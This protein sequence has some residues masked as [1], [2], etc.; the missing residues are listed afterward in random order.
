MT[1]SSLEC[2]TVSENQSARILRQALRDGDANLWLLYKRQTGGID[3]S[4]TDWHEADLGRYDLSGTD[5]TAAKL[6]GADL[7]DADLTGAI[8]RGAS[9]VG[10]NLSRTCL[11][12][13]DLSGARLRQAH[14]VDTI[15]LRVH[16]RGACFDGAD[17]MRADLRGADLSRADLRRARFKDTDGREALWQGAD[18]AEALLSGLR[19]E[20]D[21]IETLRN[22]SAALKGPILAESEYDYLFGE[23]DPAQTLGTPPGASVDAI[24]RAYRQRVKEYHP[25]RVQNLGEKIKY[26]AHHEFVRIQAAYRALMDEMATPAA[27]PPRDEN[28]DRPNGPPDQWTLDD[29]QALVGRHP[30]R[31]VY[32]YNLGVKYLEAGMREAAAQSFARAVELNPDNANARYNLKLVKLMLSL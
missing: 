30:D 5:L 21:A 8:L 2:F 16:G 28:N 23:T 17:W 31:D 18:V 1:E 25:D 10:C 15:L 7:S 24:T 32:H 19:L 12:D 6:D 22:L 14:L 3:L 11:T 27:D 9:L 29:Y 20:P 4:Q 13:A 26:V